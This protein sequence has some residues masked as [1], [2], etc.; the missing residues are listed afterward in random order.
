MNNKR[1]FI[2]RTGDK[3]MDGDREF[4][5]ISANAPT[6]TMVEDIYWHA[7]EPWEQE[8]AFKGLKQMG[9]T[10]T[11]T[12]VLSVRKK[13]DYEGQIR[14][15][16]GPNQ[17][18]EEAFKPIDKMLQIAGEYGIR[19]MIPFVDDNEWWG[20]VKDYAAF[21]GKTKDQFWTDPA[22]IQHF[23]D[24]IKYVLNRTNTY[25]GVKYKDDPA[26][27]AWET[28]NELR[29]TSYQ[30][31]AEIA[32]YIKSID[33]NHLVADG[34]YGIDEKALADPN[35]DIVS[36]HYYPTHYRNFAEQATTDR[37]KTKGK[38]PFIIGE[39]GFIPTEQLKHFLDTVID[40]GTSG[41]MIWSLRYRNKEGGFYPHTES[42]LGGVFYGSY[43]WPGFP[44]GDGFD[45]AN[46]LQTL[47]DAAFAIN[48]AE[49][50]GLPI[51]EA[52]EL[53]PIHSVSH[54]S[55]RG[56]VGAQS[57]TLERASSPSG[58]W[59]VIHAE[60]YD[61]VPERTQLYNDTTA[62][63]GQAVYYRLKAQNSTGASPYSNRVGPVS[64]NHRIVDEM[65]DFSHMYAY[66]SDLIFTG[67]N[68]PLYG[69]NV[70]CLSKLETETPQAVVYAL[71][72]AKENGNP[73]KTELV[74]FTTYADPA[75]SNEEFIVS[76]SMD[77]EQFT[78]LHMNK[79]G[80]EHSGTMGQAVYET[81]EVPGSTKYIQI[82]FP[83]GPSQLSQVEI[84]YTNEDGSRLIFPQSKGVLL[85][86][87]GTLTDNMNNFMKM[88]EHSPNVQFI[89]DSPEIF[90]QGTKRLMR[91][92]N[93]QEYAVY[94]TE[95]NMHSFELIAYAR[96]DASH[97]TL[98][99]MAFYLSSDGMNFTAYGSLEKEVHLLEGH[100]VK[101]RYSGGPLPKGMNYLKIQFPT[102]PEEFT[103]EVWNPQVSSI[104]ITM[105]D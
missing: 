15:V 93:D 33:P 12:Y 9:A 88:W 90:G 79:T 95:G 42:T 62:K 34:S 5:F 41:A 13:S 71:P 77:G 82:Q 38:K 47:S 94:R 55:W 16:L 10:A 39:Y 46:A 99:D 7:P 63:T 72:Y 84:A 27:L 76:V 32:R 105:D 92:M 75:D 48:G 3:L 102:V 24:M 19:V 58:P 11:R 35:I 80:V 101:T 50:P 66:T 25:T 59:Q 104:R 74:R 81:T 29:P 20:G 85:Q 53:L 30:W 98:A 21:E 69:G 97:Y 65:R 44:S 87:D 37:N 68:P 18:S 1:N 43:R 51:P 2:T 89:A 78:P 31:T 96:Q 56:S 40:N 52:P 54:I 28:G 49:N 67:D 57:Y 26:I 86:K 64:P 60:L 4:R 70:S 73:V 83:T 45:E 8:D 36:N 61:A 14:N 23:K 103:D 22:I 17:Y 6:L 91:T 100:W